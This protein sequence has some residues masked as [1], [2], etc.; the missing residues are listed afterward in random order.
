MICQLVYAVFT[1]SQCKQFYF[2]I[3]KLNR[4]I[5]FIDWFPFFLWPYTLFILSFESI[6]CLIFLMYSVLYFINMLFN[7]VL[8]KKTL[9]CSRFKLSAN[10]R[11]PLHC[12]LG[13]GN[14]TRKDRR[15]QNSGRYPQVGSI[16]LYVNRITITHSRL[17]LTCHCHIHCCFIKVRLV[18]LKMAW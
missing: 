10:Q 13:T 2:S 9:G 15:S 17:H 18:G 6:I 11:K 16:V 1:L 8:R 5:H 14:L 3:I 4:N 7:K 12:I